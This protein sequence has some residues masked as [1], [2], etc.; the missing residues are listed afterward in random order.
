[1]FRS[2]IAYLAVAWVI[3]QIAS[4]VF[5][6]FDA[7]DYLL[8]GLIYLLGI[9]LVFWIGFAWVYDL[10]PEGFRKTAP[11]SGDTEI[12]ESN[13][14]RLNQVIVGAVVCSI[15]L[16]IGASFWAGSQWASPGGDDTSVRIAVIPLNTEDADGDEAFLGEGLTEA[17]IEELSGTGELLVM[18]MASSKY[19]EAGIQPELDLFAEETEEVDFFVYGNAS[20]ESNQVEVELSLSRELEADPVWEKSYKADISEVRKLWAEAATDIYEI[21]GP[22]ELVANR[23]D[24][25]DLRPVHPETYELYLK[26][27]YYLNKSTVADLQRGLV[28]LQEAIDRSPGD[29]DAWAGMAAGYITW[30]HSVNPPPD[31]FPKAEA[32]AKRAIQLDSSNAEGWAALSQYHTYFGWDWDL[33]DYAFRKANELNPNLAMNHY[34]RAWYLALFGR[35]DEAIAEHRL[36]QRI[37]PFSSLHTAWL[38]ALYNWVGEY[39]KALEQARMSSKMYDDNALSMVISGQTYLKMGQVERGLDSIRKAARINGGWKDLNL[40][41]ALIK[42]GYR[43]EGIAVARELENREQTSYFSLCL[44]IIYHADGDYEKTFKW[45]ESAKGHA[46]YPWTVRLHLSDPEFRADPRFDELIRELNLPPPSPLIYQ[47]EPLDDGDVVF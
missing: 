22:G 36:A 29:P 4:T 10:T 26:G 34:H 27:K 18:S 47:G 43:E 3:V 23:S 14:R 20:R 13:T 5:P 32:A 41:P 25:S 6:A 16:L 11:D 12:R 46:F 31:A 38:G 39:D 2:V 19:L 30:G 44:A 45:L 42:Y 24:W 28:Y 7:P 1:M 40:G 8:K 9:G 35:M 37:D 17:L 21:I 15:L 33:A